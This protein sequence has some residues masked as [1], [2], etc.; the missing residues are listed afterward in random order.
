MEIE[1]R[2]RWYQQP[3][4]SYMIGGGLRAIEI[5]HRR[6]GKDEIALGVTCELAHKRVG[7][8]AG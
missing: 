8:E 1:R 7:N 2:I 5:A 4:H 6:W 3:L